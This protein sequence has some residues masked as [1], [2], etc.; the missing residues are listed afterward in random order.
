MPPPPREGTTSSLSCSERSA[1]ARSAPSSCAI[2][3]SEP[4]QN[5]RPLTDACWTS[6]RSKGGSESRREAGAAA[7]GAGG[8]R[9][10]LEGRKRV[11][12][13]GEDPL[14]GVRQLAVIALLGDV[15][16]HL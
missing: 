7:A 10:P 5:V 3:A 14:D 12:A 1:S 11:K 16:H 15:L 4:G 8:G 9:P 13:G 2:D 6:R